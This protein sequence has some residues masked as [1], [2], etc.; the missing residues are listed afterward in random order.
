MNWPQAFR[1]QALSDWKVYKNLNSNSFE[2]CH[3]IHYLLMASEKLAKA[4]LSGPTNPT[5]KS[6]MSL[7][8]FIHGCASIPNLRKYIN[9]NYN[10]SQFREYINSL[11]IISEKLLSVIPKGIK[12]INV[13]YPWES[14]S[15]LVVAPCQYTYL[16]S[17][18]IKPYELLRFITFISKMIEFEL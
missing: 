14:G 1:V 11:K 8:E 10:A 17:L 15:G 3:Q 18:G 5:Q 12:D 7:R 9:N 13:E 4:H 16:N 6:H 2:E